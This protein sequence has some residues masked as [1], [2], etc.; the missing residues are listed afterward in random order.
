MPLTGTS[1]AIH[2]PAAV[3]GALN[4]ARVGVFTGS[5]NELSSA[6]VQYGSYAWPSTSFDTGSYVTTYGA[7]PGTGAD[8]MLNSAAVVFALP[9]DG[10]YRISGVLVPNSAHSLTAAPVLQLVTNANAVGGGSPDGN[11][12]LLLLL[13]TNSGV[14]ATPQA[15][16]FLWAGRLVKGNA[17]SGDLCVG[18]DM[19]YDTA[20]TNPILAGSWMMI[21]KLA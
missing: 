12:G 18:V 15:T 21:E 16:P 13:P 19:T 10:T 17:S 20:G 9:S 7:I 3:G 11:G 4:G 14:V 6:G 8:D 2:V 1:P 5:V